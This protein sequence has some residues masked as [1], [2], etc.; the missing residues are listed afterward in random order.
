M[1]LACLCLPIVLDLSD[2]ADS[3]AAVLSALHALYQVESKVRKPYLVLVEE[4]DK[5]VPQVISGKENAIEEISVRGR[6]RG[7]GLFITTQRPS[8]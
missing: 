4:A 3:E 7:I 6:K 8:L 2:T 1:C 5:F